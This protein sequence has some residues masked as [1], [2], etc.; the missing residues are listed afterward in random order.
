[1]ALDK[2]TPQKPQNP[3]NDLFRDVWAHKFFAIAIVALSAIVGAVVC[4]WIRPVYEANA[5]IQVKT[6]SGSLSAML[7]D[8]GSFLG[9]GGSSSETE[10]QLMQSRRVVEG[11]IE[12][13]GL[14][15]V[16]EPTNILDRLLH[17]EGRADI[18]YLQFPDTSVMP[19]DRRSEPWTLVADD[20]IHFSLYDDLGEKVLSCVP[21]EL[22]AVPYQGDSVKIQVSLLKV[23]AGQKF[24]VSQ[25]L[26][27]YAVK[28]LVGKLALA[29]QGKK[30]GIVQVVYQD[31]YRDRATL[32]LDSLL[33]A[34]L[35]VNAEFGSSDMKSTL[36]LLESQL[37]EAKRV[38]DSLSTALNDYR[39]KKGSVDIV[40]ETKISLE[41]RLRLQQK[42][43]ELQQSREEKARLFDASHPF[44]VTTDKQIAALKKELAKGDYQTK[45]L[46]EAQQKI[47]TM[48]SE[49]QFAQNI[50]ADLLKRV[51]QMRLLVAGSSESAKIIDPPII[52][53]REVKPKK[54]ML[55]SGA[56]AAGAFFA[57]CLISLRKKLKGVVD[58]FEV[59]RATG[60]SVYSCILKGEKNA[61]V[62]LETLQLS[63]ELESTGK[64][65]V[66]CFSGLL[67]HVGCSFV[68]SHIAKLFAE[69]GKKVLLI[70]ADLQHG[71]LAKE[72]NLNTNLGL[73]DVL[74]GKA[75]IQESVCHSTTSGLDVLPSG[76]H[77]MCSEGVF[78]AEKFTNFIQL[79]RDFYDYIIIDTL[80]LQKAMDASIISRVS[81]EIVVIL[82]S[83][84]HM[85]DSIQD[86]FA[87]LPQGAY[88]AKVVAFNKC[89]IIKQKRG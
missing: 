65:R 30:T 2:K 34:Y 32:I 42:I 36:E 78:S 71:E 1:M 84:R 52:T 39:E 38:M 44:I 87:L 3:W 5:L 68:A 85:L 62:G 73:I 27:V 7:G 57:I 41:N 89:E 45:Q 51:E 53:P 48:T 64:S 29:E 14:Q 82:E 81:D 69:T 26:M 70:D 75:S 6:K 9:I 35:Q 40:S 76:R 72:F 31:I 28:D 66:L 47:L 88:P 55:F 67:T 60:S 20:S 21:N 12:S 59:S 15:N 61:Q 13:L 17:R 79:T 54:K 80:P 4:Q 23:R 43:I 74:A 46:P 83:G 8:V 58:P 19:V 11:A 22:C 24:E 25:R 18:R 86:G 50:Y 16:A 63:L 77:L 56:I 33:S 10:S 49:V 37:P